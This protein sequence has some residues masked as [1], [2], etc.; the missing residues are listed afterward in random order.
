MNSNPY[1]AAAAVFGLTVVAAACAHHHTHPAPGAGGRGLA[2]AYPTAANK[3]A[4]P[5]TPPGVSHVPGSAR[6][7]TQAELDDDLRPPDW[8]PDEHPAAPD[9]VARGHE[10]GATPCAGCHLMNGEGYLAVPD[11]TGLPAAYIVQ[12]V[13]AFQSG[14]RRS[15]QRDRPDTAR[16]ITTA[17]KVGDS[18]VTAAAR[19]FSSIKPRRWIRVVE[20]PTAPATRPNYGGW[21]DRVPGGGSEP[22]NGRIVELA[23]DDARMQLGDPHVGVVDYVPP[24]SV[25]RGAA[26]VRAHDRGGPSCGTCHGLDLKGQGSVPRIAGRASTYIARMLWDI[27]TG[28]R[29]GGAVAAMKAVVA[30][31]SEAEITDIAAYL[32]T[33]DP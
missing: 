12:Q 19:Y 13:K 24:G 2:W 26:L 21:L 17:L 33:L 31:F 8:F 9:V 16:M 11:L 3:T 18:E 29:S 25:A 28:A 10:G 7:Y 32:A 27:E 1:V 20:T 14:E 23:E 4:D 15:W 5:A 30:G 6:T 22:L